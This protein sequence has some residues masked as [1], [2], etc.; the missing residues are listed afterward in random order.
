MVYDDGRTSAIH[1]TEVEAETMADALAASGL[2]A[3]PCSDVCI[4]GPY[5]SR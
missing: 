1:A 2:P 3:E 5:R 4:A